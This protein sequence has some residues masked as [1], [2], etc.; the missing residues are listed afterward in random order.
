M[1]L[2]TA[3]DWKVT[4]QDHV[5]SIQRSGDRKYEHTNILDYRLLDHRSDHHVIVNGE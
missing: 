3:Q 4:G 5:A 1:E 2:R